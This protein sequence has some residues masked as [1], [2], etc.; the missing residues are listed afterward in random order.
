LTLTPTV[1]P[2]RTLTPVSTPTLL[3]R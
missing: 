1:P 3:P 2:M